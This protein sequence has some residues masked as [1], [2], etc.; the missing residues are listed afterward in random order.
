MIWAFL[1]GCVVGGVLV[2]VGQ[3]VVMSI[4]AVERVN[5]G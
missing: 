4:N 1:G 2:V 5:D 3:L